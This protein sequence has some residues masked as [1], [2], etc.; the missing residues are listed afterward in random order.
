MAVNPYRW[1]RSLYTEECRTQYSREL[2]WE[3]KEGG[4]KNLAPH[5]YEVSALAYKGLAVGRQDQSILVSGESGAGKTETIKIALQHIASVQRGMGSQHTVNEDSPIVQRVLDS[6]PLLEAFGN[7]KTV[8]NDNSSRFG[9]YLQLQFDCEDPIS[10][11]NQG[12]VIPDCILAGSQCEVYLLEKSRVVGHNQG[13]R[14]Y[15]IFYQLLAAPEKVKKSIW[16]GLV[17]KSNESFSYVGYTNT[18]SI[19]GQTDGERFAQTIQSLGVVGIKGSSLKTLFRAV[20]AVMQLGNLAFEPHSKDSERSVVTSKSEFA[21]LA[22]L[23]GIEDCSAFEKAFTERKLEARGE[24]MTVHMTAEKAK[25]ACD[26][27][28]KEI[29]ARSFLWLVRQINVATSAKMNYI[30][31]QSSFG[32]IGL[33]DIFGF[34]TFQQN[35][36]EQLCINYANEML[37]QK[38]TQDVFSAVMAEYQFEGI[39][40]EEIKYDDNTDVLDLIE[41]RTGLLA[42]LNEECFRPNGNDSTFVRKAIMTNKKSPCLICEKMFGTVEFGIKHY[43]GTVIYTAE[44]FVTKNTDRIPDDL[45]EIAKLSV[46]EI[47]SKHLNNDCMTEDEVPDIPIPHKLKKKSSSSVSATV[48]TKFKTQLNSLMGRLAETDSR[49]IRCIKPNSQK[50]PLLLEHVPTVDQLRCAGVVAAVTIS[51]SAF[52]NRLDHEHVLER[53][54]SLWPKGAEKCSEGSYDEKLHADVDTLLSGALE[55]LE[56]KE[57]GKTVKA[58]VNGKT[59]AYFRA[60]ALEFLETQRLSGM[61]FWATEIQKVARGK[62]QRNQYQKQRRAATI[63]S[64]SVRSMMARRQYQL[65]RKRATVL[66]CWARCLAAKRLVVNLR[67]FT[68]ATKIQ[69]AWRVHKDATEFKRLR[70]AAISIQCIARGMIQRPRYRQALVE[71]AEEVVLAK[72]LA[73]LQKE[74]EESEKARQEELQQQRAFAEKRA[75]QERMRKLVEEK[76]RMKQEIEQ[77]KL[78]KELQELRNQVAQQSV[79]RPPSPPPLDQVTTDPQS[80]NSVTKPEVRVVEV[81]RYIE[82]DDE[83]D[84]PRMTEEQK[85]LMEES[86]RIIEILRAENLRLKKKNEQQRK[87]FATLKENNQRLMEANSSAGSSFQSLNQHAKQLNGT[88][89]R[90]LKTVAQYRNKV[91][92]LHADMKNRQSYYRDLSS[93]YKA[94]SDARTFYEKS[95]LEIVGVVESKKCDSAIRELVLQRAMECA[96]KSQRAAGK[97]AP[98]LEPTESSSHEDELE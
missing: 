25:D 94:E 48:W 28:A 95:L 43:A 69:V 58:F 51:R 36:F 89:Q 47:I 92:K 3:R 90:L 2:V 22:D 86:G 65:T 73:K 46:N 45:K 23:L 96:A 64:A 41:G 68:Y 55:S 14:T 83:E 29:Y 35:G 61:G 63:I 80:P 62:M 5:V 82:R 57:K 97:A 50:A 8:R 34:E 71:K 77:L 66:Q 72:Q 44:T 33:L 53:F 81:V 98:E 19:E 37:Q 17:G 20:C 78:E 87:D 26:A 88:N 24:V 15:H 52:P 13:E 84:G 49:Y 60:G 74:K 40:L 6:N 59:R 75:E 31:T 54:K 93:A 79:A 67:T 21:Y 12:K 70:L 56:R 42:M 11:E 27:F 32:T 1:I 38:F 39:Q 9:K 76:E 30:G 10:A 4:R 91:A 85:S 7:A 16:K 18:H